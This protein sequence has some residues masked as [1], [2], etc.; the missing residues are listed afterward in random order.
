[1]KFPLT[2]TIDSQ[3]ELDS[4]K[5]CIGDAIAN[6][7]DNDLESIKLFNAKLKEKEIDDEDLHFFLTANEAKSYT[8]C[9]ITGLPSHRCPRLWSCDIKSVQT[10]ATY[11]TCCPKI[12]KKWHGYWQLVWERKKRL[13]RVVH[14]N[15]TSSSFLDFENLDAATEFIK[16]ELVETRSLPKQV[17][18]CF[19]DGTVP[20]DAKRF[21]WEISL[22]EAT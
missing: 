10:D 16:K 9:L 2:I 8:F 18:E 7:S 21:K 12:Y 6:W 22:E 5:D 19:E 11:P 15:N 20:D 3:K 13:I 4:I 1:M 17:V 14:G